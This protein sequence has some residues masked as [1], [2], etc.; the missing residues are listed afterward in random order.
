MKKAIIL[1][2]GGTGRDIV[3]FLE[4]I[5]SVNPTYDCLGFLDDDLAKLGQMIAGIAVLG[6]LET[7]LQ[8]GETIVFDGLGS[9]RAYQDRQR[10]IE[11]L[12]IPAEQFEPLVHPTA[13]IAPTCTIGSGCIVY[14]FTM[15]GPEASLG[16]HVT[17]LSHTVVHH[18]CIIGGYS[19][20]ASGCNISGSVTV[21]RSCYLGA[22]CSIRDGIQ[23]GEGALVGM[24]SV[25]VADLAPGSVVAGNPAKPLRDH[26]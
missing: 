10:L 16:E 13:V 11:E 6:P 18:D 14:P 7:V 9:P 4:Q 24:G 19:I 3:G 5:N 8:Y 1:G 21:G 20:I 26:E 23:V 17:V 25:V 22:G 15:I 12:L 2:A